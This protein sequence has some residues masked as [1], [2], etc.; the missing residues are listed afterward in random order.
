[1]KIVATSFHNSLNHKCFPSSQA[2]YAT[3]AF[4]APPLLFYRRLKTRIHGWRFNK[5]NFYCIIKD[6]HKLNW[7]PF[8]FCQLSHKG[9]PPFSFFKLEV[10]G[11]VLLTLRH[12]GS[13]VSQSEIKSDPLHWKCRVNHWTAREV[14]GYS[15]YRTTSR[16]RQWHPTPVLLP[17]KSHG[18]RSLVGCSPWGR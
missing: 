7:F 18:R 1:M 11:Y 14:P 8:F 9:S 12:V 6:I 3:E 17:G 13:L 5:I 10:S 16:R 4:Y 15:A 2:Y